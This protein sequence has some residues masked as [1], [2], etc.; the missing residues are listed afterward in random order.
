MKLPSVAEPF[1]PSMVELVM[2]VYGAGVR[3]LIP[4]LQRLCARYL[5]AGIGP[6]TVLHALDA[7]HTRDLP[8]VKEY[9]LR[10]VKEII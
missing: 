2:E 1:C 8:A 7:S 5:R 10:L 6:D 4:R 9:C 3:L